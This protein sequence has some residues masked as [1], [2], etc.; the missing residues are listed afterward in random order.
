[1]FA[2]LLTLLV[3]GIAGV[4]VLSIVLAIAG[5]LLSMT[6]GLIGFM[7]FK[8][9]PVLLV[10]WVVLKLID[11]GRNRRRISAADQRWLDS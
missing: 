3:A 2:S 5:A 11:K 7:L 9:A 4:V 1:M 6:F 8:V 10:G